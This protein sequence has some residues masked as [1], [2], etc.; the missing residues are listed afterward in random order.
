MRFL[1][2]VN[3]KLESSPDDLLIA[4]SKLTPDQKYTFLEL[5]RMVRLRNRHSHRMITWF[6]MFLIYSIVSVCL[7]NYHSS[8]IL[9]NILAEITSGFLKYILTAL[10]GSITL[11]HY[12]SGWNLDKEILQLSSKLPLECQDLFTE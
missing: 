1:I 10:L 5:R 6:W 9:A 4:M 12:Y 7:A 2:V 8:N 11:F 3:K